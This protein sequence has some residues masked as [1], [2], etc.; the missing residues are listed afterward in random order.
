MDYEA[1][2]V[3]LDVGTSKVVALVGEVAPSGSVSI[4]GKGVEPS[5]GLRKGQVINIEQTV[6][7]IRGAVTAA[8]R[9]SGM[10]LEAAF[11][12]VGGAHVASE[13]SKGLVA[14]GG[15]GR[16]VSREDVERVTEVA[17]AVSIP[18]S[19]EILHVVPRDFTVDGQEGVKDP[20]GMIALRLEVETHIVSG[21]APALQNLSKCV[22]LAEIGRAHV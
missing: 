9:L 6:A 10:H 3:A 19:R 1:V 11:V 8:E 15:Q 7:S 20:L 16:E 22:K 17:K 5:T 12:S 21:A 18:S 14:V 4:I 2:L 13:N